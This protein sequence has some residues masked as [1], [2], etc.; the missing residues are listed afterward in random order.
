[1]DRQAAW[2]VIVRLARAAGIEKSITPHSL[3]HTYVTL[4]LDAGAD[5]RDVQ[6][7]AG[8]RDPKTTM[9]YDRARQSLDRNPTFAV[10]AAVG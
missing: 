6:A 1:M 8:H 4:A 2:K 10:A 3:R 9:G 5:L 7:S